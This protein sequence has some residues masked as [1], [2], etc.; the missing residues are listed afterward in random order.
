[1]FPCKETGNIT[2]SV[3]LCAIARHRTSRSDT[4]FLLPHYYS[5]LVTAIVLNLN[6][7][8]NDSFSFTK[9]VWSIHHFISTLLFI[10]S[11]SSSSGNYILESNFVFFF[12]HPFYQMFPCMETAILTTSMFLTF[13]DIENRSC[14][15]ISVL[16]IK[17]NKYML[18][19]TH[20]KYFCRTKLAEGGILIFL[21]TGDIYWSL[22]WKAHF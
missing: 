12:S 9:A 19:N 13:N 22:I 21:N 16:W 1:M 7:Q 6:V 11:S 3:L 20:L 14:A 17:E 18:V 10:R 5:G 8:E 15:I 2:I 4:C